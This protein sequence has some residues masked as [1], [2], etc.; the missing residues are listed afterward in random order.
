MFFF[1]LLWSGQIIVLLQAEGEKKGTLYL[2]TVMYENKFDCLTQK[3]KNVRGV[4]CDVCHCQF[5]H[6]HDETSV[7]GT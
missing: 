4:P 5:Y 1:F 7:F 2:L 3:C 6:E